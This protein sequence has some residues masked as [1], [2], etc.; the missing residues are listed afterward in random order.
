VVFVTLGMGKSCKTIAYAALPKNLNTIAVGYGLSRGNILTDHTLPVSNL[1]VTQQSL[2]G[3]F[4]HTFDTARKDLYP[5][6]LF[7]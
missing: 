7:I 1:K 2:T 6:N 3:A 5:T 4:L